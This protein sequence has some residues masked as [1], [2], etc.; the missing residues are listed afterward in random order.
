MEAAGDKTFLPKEWV[1]EERMRVLMGH[2]PH[3]EV[4]KTARHTFWSAAIHSWCRATRKPCFT[5]R[6]SE[7]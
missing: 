2:M 5:L 4:S 1:S 6:V 7:R 3:D